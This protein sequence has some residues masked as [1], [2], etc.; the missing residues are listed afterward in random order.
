MLEILPKVS[1]IVPCRNEKKWIGSCLDSIC[2]NDFPA[3]D[4]EVLIVDGMS[5][6]GTREVIQECICKH[7]NVRLIDNPQKITPTALNHG[8]A[9]SRGEIIMRMDAHVDY[10]RDYIRQLVDL[11]EAR[12]ADNVG[13]LCLTLPATDTPMA[14]A[15]AIGMSHPAGVGNSYF[16]IGTTEERWVDTVPFG[17]YRKT[18]F[19]RIGM[20]DEELVRNQDDEF[21]L[22]LIRSGGKILLTPKVVCRY[23]ARDTLPKLWRMYYQYG[24]F[25]PLVVRKVKGVMTLRQLLPPLFVLSL[26]AGGLLSPFSRLFAIAWAS[27]LAIYIAALVACAVPVVFKRGLATGLLLVPVFMTLHVS[28][29][30]G[31]LRGICDFWIRRR[32]WSEHASSL[33]ISR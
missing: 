19:E 16:R 33:P 4:M 31:Y 21:N 30:L 8:I 14:S 25:K 15:I 22:R 23:Y 6:D 1:I 13:G 2:A 11:L 32:P 3:L 27:L 24:Y 12:D 5:N 26:A 9:Q 7:H 29:G 18:V 17:C 20:F 10:P 28:Y